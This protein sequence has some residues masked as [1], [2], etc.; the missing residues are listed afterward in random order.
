MGIENG[1]IEEW[2]KNVL[3][4]NERIEEEYADRKWRTKGRMY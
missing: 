4:G 1:R 2:R 3:T